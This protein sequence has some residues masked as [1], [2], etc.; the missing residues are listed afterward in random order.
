MIFAIVCLLI[1]A[2]CNNSEGTD[3]RIPSV[4]LAA[5]A[6][7]NETPTPAPEAVPEET[8]TYPGRFIDQEFPPIEHHDLTEPEYEEKT[9][10]VR[11]GEFEVN[12]TNFAPKTISRKERV[13][14]KFKTL[15]PDDYSSSLVGLSKLLGKKSTQIY[16][17]AVGPGAVC[18]TN[19]WIT[20]VSTGKPRNIFRSE[21]FGSFRD[22]M[23]VFDADGDGIYE[24]VQSDSAFRYFMGDCGSCSPEP[25]AVFKYDKKARRYL[26]AYG[27]QPDFVKE[28]MRTMEKWLA[29]SY[30]KLNGGEDRALENDFRR[31]LVAHIVDLIYLGEERK[32]W[33]VLKGYSAWTDSKNIRIEIKI[34]LKQSKFIQA[35]KRSP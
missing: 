7:P 1:Q 17:V 11:T 16:T 22:P 13:L 31:A 33:A 29:D 30:V 35:L 2:G 26:P 20:D 27:I 23:E 10:S 6:S 34:R 24:L 5:S 8:S 25:R 15:T 19:Y 28:G 21:D 12:I 4:D 9:F 18:C 32:A 14:Y 3:A